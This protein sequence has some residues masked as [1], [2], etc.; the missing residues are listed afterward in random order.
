MT[1]VLDVPMFAPALAGLPAES[2]AEVEE[3]AKA[4]LPKCEACDR[5]LR[6]RE[7]Q[8]AGIGPCCAAKIGRQVIAE[9]RATRAA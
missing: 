8:E 2:W 4:A 5:R 9:R 1:A 7:S 3:T 6:S